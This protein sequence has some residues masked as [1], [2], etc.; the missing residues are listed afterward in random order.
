[1]TLHVFEGVLEEGGVLLWDEGDH[2]RGS[3]VESILQENLASGDVIRIG[4]F[5][6]TLPI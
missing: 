6:R 2:V 4:E 1:V 3:V 5:D